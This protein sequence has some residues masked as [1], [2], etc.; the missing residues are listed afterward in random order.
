MPNRTPGYEPNCEDSRVAERVD[1]CGTNIGNERD[2]AIIHIR[3]PSEWNDKF[4]SILAGNECY[5]FAA[6]GI[7]AFKP[8]TDARKT[9]ASLNAHLPEVTGLFEILSRAQ[10]LGAPIKQGRGIVAAALFGSAPGSNSFRLQPARS[11]RAIAECTP[12]H[13]R[14]FH[15]PVF[16]A[17]TDGVNHGQCPRNDDIG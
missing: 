12:E 5:V 8:E 4:T 2:D 17:S 1:R 15:I 13:S 10:L 16:L 11:K 3:Q 9:S 14:R 7:A 6:H